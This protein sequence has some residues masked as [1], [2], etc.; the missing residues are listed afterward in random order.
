MKIGNTE[1]KLYYNNQ[2][3]QEI[4]ELCGGSTNLRALI[5]DS[6]DNPVEPLKQLENVA[7]LVRILANNE[8]RKNN[9]LIKMGVIA[10]EPKEEFTDEQFSVIL[11]ASMVSS[12]FIECVETI[13]KA[14]TFAVPDSV[15]MTEP[16]I[17]LEEIEAEKNP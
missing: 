5:F 6:E 8:I 9:M 17:D 1:I 16:D 4:S 10:G 12:Y 14:S 3:A 13:R 15:K 7:K 11:D 2:A